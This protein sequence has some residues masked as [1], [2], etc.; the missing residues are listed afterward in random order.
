MRFPKLLQGSNGHPPASLGP[1]LDPVSFHCSHLRKYGND[2]FAHTAADGPKSS[3]VQNNPF[4][5]KGSYV[6]L[7]VDRVA[8]EAVDR[9]HI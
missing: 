4:A 3:N 6:R 5:E 9:V 8:T 2:E 7:D 1:F